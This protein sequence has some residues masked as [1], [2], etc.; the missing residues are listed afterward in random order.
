M[1]LLLFMINLYYIGLLNDAAMTAG[2]GIGTVLIQILGFT[3][4]MGTNI[5]QETLTSHSFGANNLERCGVLLNRGRMILLTV[6]IPISF[7]FWFSE[8]IFLV[9]G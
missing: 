1:G 3:V 5:A 9:I 8:S 2:L 6:F 4:A 7:A